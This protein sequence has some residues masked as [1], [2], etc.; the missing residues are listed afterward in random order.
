MAKIKTMHVYP[1]IPIRV[2]DWVAFFEDEEGDEDGLRGWGY[3]EEE[4]I[5]ALMEMT[6]E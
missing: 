1:P 3:T 4:A 6:D 2:F 5:A